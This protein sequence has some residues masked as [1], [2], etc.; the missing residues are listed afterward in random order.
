MY[1]VHVLNQHQATNRRNLF[2]QS[3]R[4]KSLFPHG[5][6]Q[7]AQVYEPCVQINVKPKNLFL[8]SYRGSF[9]L[10]LRNYFKTKFPQSTIAAQ[11]G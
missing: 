3:Q 2:N 9:S 11:N 5:A 1:I 4:T 6:A 7:E 10:L 8:S